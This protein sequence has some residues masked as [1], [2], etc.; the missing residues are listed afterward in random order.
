MT[1]TSTDWRTYNRW[2]RRDERMAELWVRDLVRYLNALPWLGPDRAVLDYG[3]G[4]FDVGLA[5]AHRVGRVDGFDIEERTVEHA[6][7]R[8]PVG[9]RVFNHSEAIPQASYDLIVANSVFQYLG[10]DE[11]VLQTLKLFRSLLR[12][13]GRGEV[14]L[15]DL[16]PLTYSSIKDG[17]RSLH[18]AGRNGMMAAML[19]HLWKAAFKAG[20][21]ELHRIE[22]ERLGELA[23]AA[24]FD[25]RRL[26]KNLTPSR[27]RYSCLLT[28]R[29]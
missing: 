15:G 23:D 7:Q 10:N 16:I 14:L 13:G 28:A 9:S 5:V 24:G 8:A 25:C 21:L 4:Y 27:Q 3:C 22:P 19:V 18:V 17:F 12:P 1:H 2:N 6:R 26:P 20:P 11:G 29:K